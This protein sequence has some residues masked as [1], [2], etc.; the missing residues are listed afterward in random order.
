MYVKLKDV[1]SGDFFLHLDG[2]GLVLHRFSE[3]NEC[4]LWNQAKIS[5]R[6]VFNGDIT[7]QNDL[8]EIVNVVTVPLTFFSLNATRTRAKLRTSLVEHYLRFCP[9]IDTNIKEYLRSADS[10]ITESTATLV[11]HRKH[12]DIDNPMRIDSPLKESS[13]PSLTPIKKKGNICKGDFIVFHDDMRGHRIGR[14]RF[15]P[16]DIISATR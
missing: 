1:N 14:V 9:N 11:K 5:S 12:N 2:A 7:P 4:E 13:K 3:R 8:V 16:C 15:I 6:F 10:F